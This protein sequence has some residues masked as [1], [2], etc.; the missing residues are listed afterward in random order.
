MWKVE[1]QLKKQMRKK[2]EEEKLYLNLFNL[3][4]H[5]QC[6]L[7]L[8]IW[9][10]VVMTLFCPKKN[11]KILVKVSKWQK[12]PEI[13]KRQKKKKKNKKGRKN[14]THGMVVGQSVFY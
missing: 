4:L 9:L 5:L 2:E 3:P 6:S 10:G 7:N 11:T 13:H 12:Y 14:L 8:L 1:N